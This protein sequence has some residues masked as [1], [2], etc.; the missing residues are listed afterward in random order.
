MKPYILPYNSCILVNEKEFVFDENERVL[1]ESLGKFKGDCVCVKEH[2]KWNYSVLVQCSDLTLWI[3]RGDGLV[4]EVGD[5][6][7]GT[8]YD[9]VGKH[10]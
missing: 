6:V 1:Q 10:N 5:R 9:I 7:I 4:M 3:I 2:V 8:D